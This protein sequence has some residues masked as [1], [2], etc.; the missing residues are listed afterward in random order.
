MKKFFL[1]MRTKRLINAGTLHQQHSY[2][3]ANKIGLLFQGNNPDNLKE[4]M[5]FSEALIREHKSVKMMM[6]LPDGP[7]KDTLPPSCPFFSPDSFSFL[8]NILDE[9]LKAFIGEPFHFLFHLG[10]QSNAYLELVLA[11]SAANYRMGFHQPGLEPFY[12]FML[13]KRSL[14]EQAHWSSMLTYAKMIN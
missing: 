11:S 2:D 10:E 9:D 13:K 7:Q 1:N 5:E 4:A 14:Q 12:E 3:Q 8:G 6:F